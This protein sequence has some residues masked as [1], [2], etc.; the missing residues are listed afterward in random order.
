[1]PSLTLY[2]DG[3]RKTV[4]FSVRASIG[5]IVSAWCA[6]TPSLDSKNLAI[7]TVSEQHSSRLFFKCSESFVNCL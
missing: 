1:M 7:G 5:E 4:E 2:L 6:L 3:T